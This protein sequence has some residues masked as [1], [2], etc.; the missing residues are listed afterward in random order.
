MWNNR[1]W[2]NVNSTLILLTFSPPFLIIAYIIRS[3]KFPEPVH[4]IL[5]VFLLGVGIT[6]FAG[7]FNSILIPEGSN[8][9]YLAGVTEE[10]LKYLVLLFYVKNRDYFDEPMDGI[11]YGVLISLGFATLENYQY[12]IHFIEHGQEIAIL[13]AFSAIPLHAMCGVVMGFYF[14]MANFYHVGKNYLKALFVPMCIHAA[15][16]FIA[17]YSFYLTTIF[18]LITFFQ[19]KHLHETFV[20]L[21]QKKFIEGEIKL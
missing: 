13:R 14:G 20:A 1:D 5:K 17:G 7:I 2:V 9:A 18:I 15:Y 21:Q 11:V 19:V 6:F 3:D 16:N 4:A 8:R 10:S 12:V